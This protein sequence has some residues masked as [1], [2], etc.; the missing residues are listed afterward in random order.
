MSTLVHKATRQNDTPH[1]SSYF[2]KPNPLIVSGKIAGIPVPLLIDSGSSLTL[3]NK[4]LFSNLPSYLRQQAQLPPPSLS[5]QLAD[6]SQLKIHYA[7]SLPVTVSNSTHC[8]TVYVAPL[9]SRLCIIGND[10]I[11]LHNLQIDG[12]Q[13]TAYCKSSQDQ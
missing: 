5:V 13:Q 10:L 2:T 6:R 8:H 4:R 12:R 3:I 9:L 7:L 1:L 11:Q